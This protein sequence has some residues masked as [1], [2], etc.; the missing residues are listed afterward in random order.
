MGPIANMLVNNALKQLGVTP[1]TVPV[2]RAAELI[3]LLASKIPF[4]DKREAFRKTMLEKSRAN[5]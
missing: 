1:T 3:D 5:A 4:D 2:N